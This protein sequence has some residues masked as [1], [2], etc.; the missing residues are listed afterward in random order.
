MSSSP[1]PRLTLVLGGARSGK[2]RYAEGLV[3]AHRAPWLYI[4]TAEG[5]D[6]EMRQRIGEHRARRGA[7]WETLDVA[8]ELPEAIALRDSRHGVVMIDCLTLWL[9]NAMLAGRD[10]A[11]ERARLLQALRC[12]DKVIV[13][14]SNEVGLGLV[15]DTPLGRLF[16]DEQ[17]RLN[18][19]VAALADHVVFMAAGLPM[20]LKGAAA[21]I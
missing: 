12:A 7:E 20:V 15:P 14:V 9:S 4:A 2:S 13:A 18:A 6:E 8:L 17:G 1:T 16:R 19:E 11:A 3:A 21:P 10:P 5:L